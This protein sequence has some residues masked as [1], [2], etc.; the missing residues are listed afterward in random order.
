MSDLLPAKSPRP[1]AINAPENLPKMG[2]WFYVKYK[3]WDE[4]E[5]EALACV[6]HVASNHIVF[7]WSSDSGGEHSVRT[8][9]KD[10]MEETRPEPKWREVIQKR[11]ADKQAELQAAV[12]G[13]A[14]ACR[15]ASLIQDVQAPQVATLLPSVTR[16]SPHEHK[17]RLLALKN[18]KLPAMQ[19]DI[20]N[21]TK[22]MVALQK[23]LYLPE[24]AIARRMKCASEKIDDRLF[25]LEIYAGLWER[26]EQI[27]EGDP[28]PQETPI[29]VRQ[30]LLFMD[31]ECLLD[32]DKGGMNYAKL[33]DFDR[34]ISK[35]ENR[36][37]LIPEPRCIVAF[38]V[39]RHA[40][41][42]GPVS[43][44]MD[45][46]RQL[47][48]MKA[49]TATYLLMRNGEQMFR[50]CTDVNFAP[51]LLPLREEFNQP[52][53]KTERQYRGIGK[54]ER[55]KTETVTPDHLDYDQYVEERAKTMTH[56]NR[57]LF[58]IQ[59][60]L[61]RSQCFRPHPPINLMD[62]V[63]AEQWFRPLHDE[64]DGLPSANP[65]VWNTYRDA[66]NAKIKTGSRVYASWTE[67]RKGWGH[68]RWEER[69]FTATGLHE[70][71]QISRNK[72]KV[73]ISWPQEDREGWQY[74]T[75]WG[76]GYGKYG[77]WPTGKKNHRWVDIENCFNVSTYRPGDYKLF[78]CD[79]Y[80][81]GAYL[82]W[83]PQLLSA[84]RWHQQQRDPEWSAFKK[85]KN[86]D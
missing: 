38:R 30:M 77:R 46:F 58:L 42:Y 14:D 66:H 1:T 9:F 3:D 22:E 73:R 71:T 63:A 35:K 59:G 69:E 15:D 62:P 54:P 24:R 2:E 52:F 32:Y 28:A 16:R 34:W 13:L 56:Y 68:N 27:A 81:R 53:E 64:E 78:L 19:K 25:A 85:K 11:V 49:D 82:Q 4:K 31:E 50:L 51:R 7:S 76:R 86:E 83:A 47:D 57:V 8:H 45:A 41:D 23:D 67:T 84:E 39:R 44:I 48:E 72:Q 74:P 80:L 55:Y 21:I 12:M 10:L 17:A 75:G 60:L 5:E 26:I 18:E 70:V 65:P 37:R 79:R 6:T 29:T 36:N 40:K 33:R 43:S 20:E 61:D